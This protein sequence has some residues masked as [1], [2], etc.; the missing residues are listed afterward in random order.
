GVGEDGRFVTGIQGRSAVANVL[1]EAAKIACSHE[2]SVAFLPN[3]EIKLSVSG[4]RVTVADEVL[5]VAG[6]TNT[7]NPCKTATVVPDPTPR[8]TAGG[9]A[10]L[11]TGL[12][13]Q[14][15]GAPRTVTV[16]EQQS[17]LTVTTT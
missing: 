12:T 1:T 6:C 2:G 10:V 9:K 4:K 15:D 7:Q 11:T 8:L 13:Y 14:T 3:P 17:K 5:T 16:S